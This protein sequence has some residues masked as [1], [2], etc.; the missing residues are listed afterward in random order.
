MHRDP[1]A[2]WREPATAL[3]YARTATQ[4]GLWES[5]RIM[6]QRYFAL[7][8]DLLEVGCGGG[9]AGLGMLK[10]GYTGLRLTDFSEPMVSITRG[11]LADANPAWATLVAQ[12]DATTLSY[13]DASFDGVIYAFN[14]LMCLPNREARL[15]A[16]CSIHRVL[17]PQG[18]LIFTAPDREKGKNAAHWKDQTLS[19][20]GIPGNRWHE[21][22]TSP[23][24]M[25][26]S[27]EQE[28]YAELER[29]GFTTLTSPLSTEVALDSKAARDFAGETRFYVARKV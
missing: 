21:T 2:H 6:I 1:K 4:I 11:V 18:I 8:D 3:M 20:D 16:L 19:A 14:G 23:V 9:R 15:A 13:A 7:T 24:F 10:L 28:T 26:S 12:Q 27:T 17:C 29:C 25:H 5:E 22:E